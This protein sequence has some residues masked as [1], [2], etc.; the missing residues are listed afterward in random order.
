IYRYVMLK[1]NARFLKL[2]GDET[3]LKIVKRLLSGELC[4]CQFIPITG[5]AQSTVSSQLRALEKEGVL[6]SRRDG[7]NIYYSINFRV[8]ANSFMALN[9][10]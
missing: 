6:Q 9:V 1:E 3:K 4:S 10:K 2:L 5:R 8:Q 7:R